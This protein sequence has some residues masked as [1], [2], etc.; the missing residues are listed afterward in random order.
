MYIYYYYIF[1]FSII[2]LQEL[3]P[4]KFYMLLH[5][6]GKQ[7]KIASF[8]LNAEC[9]FANRHSYYHSVRAEL[10]FILWRIGLM[11]APNKT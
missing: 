2:L 1:L 9:C 10:P 11:H 5:Y 3:T 7:P 4:I 6:L 8:H